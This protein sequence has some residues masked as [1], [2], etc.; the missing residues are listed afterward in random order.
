MCSF[1]K[2]EIATFAK[3][4]NLKKQTNKQWYPVPE[5]GIKGSNRYQIIKVPHSNDPPTHPSWYEAPP[6]CCHET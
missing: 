4:K 3:I 1:S 6:V 2:K 5:T